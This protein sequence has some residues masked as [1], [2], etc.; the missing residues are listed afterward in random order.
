MFAADLPADEQV[1][2]GSVVAL[3]GDRGLRKGGIGRV[4]V[5]R[6]VGLPAHPPT[7][8]HPGTTQATHRLTRRQPDI[9]PP[10]AH[11]V[12]CRVYNSDDALST[13]HIDP[14]PRWP[15]VLRR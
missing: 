6:S 5:V 4:A 14:Q 1:A 11:R 13:L 10:D 7:Q 15:G 2:P 12:C 3:I 8:P 9:R